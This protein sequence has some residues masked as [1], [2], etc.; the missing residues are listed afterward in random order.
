MFN[1]IEGDLLQAVHQKKITHFAHGAN[2]WST[3]GAG[4]AGKIAQQFPA[5]YQA[6]VN[7]HLMPEQRLGRVSGVDL[8]GGVRGYNLYTQFYPGPNARTDMIRSSLTLMLE[9][10]AE[11]LVEGEYVKV[12]I[13]AIGCGI[14]GLQFI[15]VARVVHEVTYTLQQDYPGRG[16]E[17]YMFV[18]NEQF[19]VERVRAAEAGYFF[20][21]EEIA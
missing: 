2:C 3:M 9:S 16:V 15:E 1:L 10:I 7:F 13:P 5:L 14:G 6:D 4:I 17:L 21:V 11:G 8:P 12:G 18:F 19:N 20:Q